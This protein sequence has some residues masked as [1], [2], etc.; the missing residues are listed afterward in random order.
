MRYDTVFTNGVVKSREKYLLGNKLERMQ[1]GTFE[2]ALKTLKESG[3]GGDAVAAADDVEQLIRAEEISLNNFIREYAPTDKFAAFLLA[4]NDFHNAEGLVKCLYAGADEDKILA[5]TGIFSIERLTSAVRDDNYDGLPDE[6]KKAIEES[7]NLFKDGKANGLNVDCLF[8][9][10]MFAYMQ[11]LAR[12]VDLKKLLVSKA[13]AANISS[14]LRSRDF[15][16]AQ[17]MYVKGGKLPLSRIKDLC[18]LPFDAIEKG[19]FPPYAKAAAAEISKQKPATTFERMADDYPLTELYKT[20]YD[21]I[22][23]QPFLTYILKRRAE[24]KNVRIITVSLAAGLTAQ[25][26]KNKIRLY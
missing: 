25:Q 14:A 3:F 9:S 16:I 26:I 8:K 13:D 22:A 10:Q 7:K 23:T 19:D 24:I 1:E 20:K 11:V 18:E 15:A 2:D 6:L 21:M 12:N 17:M 4:E 5:P